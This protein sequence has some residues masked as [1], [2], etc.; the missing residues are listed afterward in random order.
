MLSGLIPF[1]Y[2]SYLLFYTLLQHTIIFTLHYSHTDGKIANHN[3]VPVTSVELVNVGDLWECTSL[4]EG[5][6][7]KDLYMECLI[8]LNL[9]FDIFLLFP[10][11]SSSSF[12]VSILFVLFISIQIGTLFENDSIEFM[13]L[14]ELK[15]PSVKSIDGEEG[16]RW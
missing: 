14:E 1:F 16:Y 10:S 12:S 8:E 11:Y 15:E 2:Y 5:S 4:L 7:R 13:C 6:N 9:E 3:F